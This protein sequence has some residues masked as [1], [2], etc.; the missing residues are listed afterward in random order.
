MDCNIDDDFNINR[1]PNPIGYG[2]AATHSGGN[3]YA[4]GSPG[5]YPYSNPT[6]TR[7]TQTS[8]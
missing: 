7:H 8:A 2:Y 6:A 4:N 3:K 5:R 1:D